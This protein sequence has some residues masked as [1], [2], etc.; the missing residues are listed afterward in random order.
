MRA[1]VLDSG[2]KVLSSNFICVITFTFG[3]MSLGKV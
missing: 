2:L 3:L 1:K